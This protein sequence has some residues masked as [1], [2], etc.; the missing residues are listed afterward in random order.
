MLGPAKAAFSRTFTPLTG[1]RKLSPSQM[2]MNQGGSCNAFHAPRHAPR[3][4]RE[5]SVQRQ[6]MGITQG[7]QSALG[8]G[9]LTLLDATQ[10]SVEDAL[11]VSLLEITRFSRRTNR[12]TVTLVELGRALLGCECSRGIHY[13]GELLPPEMCICMWPEQKPTVFVDLEMRELR[14]IV[15][16]Q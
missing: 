11:N 12:G 13:L 7:F 16:R 2:R 8:C 5:V 9:L 10:V 15:R 6:S 3:K 1:Q 14:W 4:R